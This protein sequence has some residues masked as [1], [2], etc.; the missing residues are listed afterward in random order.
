MPLEIVRNDLTKMDVDVI[1]NAANSRLQQG[2]GVCGAIFSAAGAMELQ[3]ACDEIGE[4][5]VGEAVLTDGFGLPAKKIIHTVGPIWQGGTENEA[6]LLANCY[7]NA[8]A[9]AV[10]N[11]YESIA[12]PLISSGI[13]GYPK[14]EALQVAMDTIKAFLVNHDMY[15]YMVVF[16]REVVQISKALQASI[17]EYIDERYVDEKNIQFQRQ[18]YRLDEEV[19]L[20]QFESEVFSIEEPVKKRSLQDV[21]NELD[22]SFSEG[23][24]RLIDQKGM[25]DVETY[26][27]AN[28]DRRLFS[29]IRNTEAYTPLKKTVLAFAIALQCNLDETTDLLAKAGYTLSRSS[30]FDIIIE[31]FIEEKN[32]NIHEINEALFNF[33]QVLLGA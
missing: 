8:L 33:E 21:L 15:V 23:L 26:K 9:L 10:A 27:K 2:G 11:G 12:F 25:T 22:E 17:H 29:K 14:E 6:V 3:A 30:K 32:F 4:C 20:Y 28:V 31:Y 13:Y 19:E 16:D 5:P 7:K 24:L 18:S 1:V